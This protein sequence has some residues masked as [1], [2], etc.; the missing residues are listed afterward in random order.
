MALTYDGKM[1]IGL[2]DP[3][4]TLHIVGTS[5]ITDKSFFGADVRVKN[6]LVVD[7]QISSNLLVIDSI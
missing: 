4:N 6:N 5:T 1:G 3:I 7:N 2:T